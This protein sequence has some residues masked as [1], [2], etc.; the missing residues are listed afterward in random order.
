MS[1]HSEKTL[2]WTLRALRLNNNRERSA[3]ARDFI[4]TK[5]DTEGYLW[6]CSTVGDQSHS[7]TLQHTLADIHQRGINTQRTACWEKLFFFFFFSTTD[8]SFRLT[9]EWSVMHIL[10]KCVKEKGY[11][12]L[13][14]VPEMRKLTT[15]LWK[16]R[17]FYKIAAWVKGQVGLDS[18]FILFQNIFWTL[19]L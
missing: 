7:T 16:W 13:F 17:H 19:K 11:F 15:K 10:G 18:C 2:L 6:T 9:F 14:T 1:A 3:I 8:P 4:V 5:F 12:K